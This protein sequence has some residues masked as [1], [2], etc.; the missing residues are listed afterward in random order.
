LPIVSTHSTAVHPV[1]PIRPHRVRGGTTQLFGPMY[2]FRSGNGPEPILASA[3]AHHILGIWGNAIHANHE[4]P[5]VFTRSCSIGGELA[6]PFWL[7]IISNIFRAP[8]SPPVVMATLNMFF[9]NS[10]R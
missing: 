10:Y 9:L 1:R 3:C 2:G 4:S 8:G 5:C 7:Q 6:T